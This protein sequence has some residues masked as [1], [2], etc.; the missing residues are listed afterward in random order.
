[1]MN[2]L[3]VT[4]SKTDVAL[5]PR[6]S[7]TV[8]AEALGVELGAAPEAGLALLLNDVLPVTIA[9]SRHGRIAV[10]FQ[11]SEAKKTSQDVWI[12]ALSEA[13][14]WGLD[15]ETQRFVVVDRYLALL[16]TPQPLA[17]DVLL[18]RLYEVIAIAYA[19]AQLAAKHP[20]DPA[21]DGVATPA[22]SIEGQ[23]Q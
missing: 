17:K 1:M 6:E 18:T 5:S 23:H 8:I 7:M 14:G 16:W 2:A 3:Q 15:G 10:C 12:S 4:S 11:I 19:V 13:A 20:M 21:Q 9:P 22:R